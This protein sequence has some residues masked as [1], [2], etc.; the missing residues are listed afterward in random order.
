MSDFKPIE[1]QEQFDAM[2]KD[3]LER[4]ERSFIEKY[5]NSEEL[6]TQLEAKDGQIAELSKQLEEVN[7]NFESSK[8]QVEGLNA[9]VLQYETD[10]VKTRVAHEVGIPYE[11]ASRL[12]GDNE[13]AIRADAKALA[14][15]MKASTT[16]PPPFK[17]E[18]PP[19]EKPDTRKQFADWLN[20]A[21]N[22]NEN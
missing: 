11:M 13:E 2:V 5:G 8:A 6:K 10:S 15:M 1:S 3:R 17:P 7:K 19:Q 20:A 12:N 14:K 22:P 18:L 16:T 9:K 21:T 4:A